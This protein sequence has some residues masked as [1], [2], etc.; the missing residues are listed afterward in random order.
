MKI[1][2]NVSNDAKGFIAL[3]TGV[4][5]QSRHGKFTS[6]RL[7]SLGGVDPE[8][9]LEAFKQSLRLGVEPG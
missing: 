2:G 3:E 1:I 7:R 4:D 5:W 6:L 9:H 8:S